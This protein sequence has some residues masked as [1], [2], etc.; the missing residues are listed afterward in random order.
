MRRMGSG[1]P[2]SAAYWAMPLGGVIRT[3]PATRIAGRRSLST[4]SPMG[5]ATQTGSPGWSAANARFHAESETRTAYSSRGR[6]GL[7]ARDIGRASG[8]SGVFSCSHANCVGRNRNSGGSSTS[9]AWVL[10]VRGRETATRPTKRMVGP[11]ALAGLTLHRRQ[12]EPLE[13]PRVPA[14]D[15]VLD[16]GLPAVHALDRLRVQRNRLLDRQVRPV[17]GL[18][19][20]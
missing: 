16:L 4:K 12:R 6:V 2:L 18:D 17:A 3:P 14:H 8:P 19:R 13:L 1:G 15:A 11:K 7:V 5:P 10:G 9:I 20:L